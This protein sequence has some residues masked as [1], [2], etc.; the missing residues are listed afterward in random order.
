MPSITTSGYRLLLRPLLFRLPPEAAQKVAELA[1]RRRLVWRAL[2]PAFRVEDQRLG[3]DFCGLRLT[4]P[5]GLAAGFDKDC[6][7][8]P[9]LAAM[10]FGYL[11][12]GTVTESPQPGNPKPRMLRYIDHLSL[13]NALGFPGKGLQ[14]AARHLERVRGVL[15]DTAVAVSISGVSA[16][17]IVR[18]HRLLEPLAD[19]IELNIS[20]PNTAGLKAFHEAPALADLIGRIND[21]R[22]KP[23]MVKLPPYS[24]SS[25]AEPSDGEAAERVL[26]MV[27]TC[28]DE[29]VDA[30]TVANSRPIADSRLSTGAGGL[31]GKAVFS[32]VLKM[33]AEI[34]AEVGDRMAISACG[35]IFSG[36]DAWQAL[37][38]GAKTV[39]LYTG[40]V[41]R[42]PGIVAQI[43]R[44]LLSIMKREG[45]ESL[46]AAFTKT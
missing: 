8:L 11:V 6:A 28:L 35:G 42:G 40:L 25:A 27:K 4:N 44:D 24:S 13:I 14:N 45:V 39:Q 3:V 16:D 22:A 32:D 31:S 41:Y 20:S 46:R 9:S 29:G 37:K 30:V 36:E 12:G 43:N 15:G 7:L 38:A 23:L 26:A 34:K 17:E 5:V 1:L 33:V 21:G 10:G 19:I 2:A 18:C